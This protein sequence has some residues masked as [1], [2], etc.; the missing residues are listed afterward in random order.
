MRPVTQ[1][2][3]NHT[4]PPP[5]PISASPAL[6]HPS[7]AFDTLNDTLSTIQPCFGARGDEITL[8]TSPQEF[9]DKLIDMI[10]RA[11]RRIIISSLYIGAEEAE[12]VSDSGS[13]AV[14]MLMCRSMRLRLRYRR[15]RTSA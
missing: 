15:G 2:R 8:L 5:K 10:K 4:A 7:P 6:P 14:H 11:R 3:L 9:Y 1:I 13:Q 12:L